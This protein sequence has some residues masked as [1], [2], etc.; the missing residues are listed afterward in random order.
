MLFAVD[1][2]AKIKLITCDTLAII[3]IAEVLRSCLNR[4]LYAMFVI[5]SKSNLFYYLQFFILGMFEN[6][7]KS[8]F[9]DFP[10]LSFT[11]CDFL[12]V[13]KLS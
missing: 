7:N 8:L 2:R 6:N 4:L 12:Y 1:K 9:L 3:L 13:G 5:A 11:V 10:Y